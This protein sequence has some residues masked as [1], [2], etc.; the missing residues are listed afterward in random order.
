MR[1][2]TMEEGQQCFCRE[3]YFDLSGQIESST[4]KE[5]KGRRSFRGRGRRGKLLLYF[6]STVAQGQ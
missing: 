5:G 4:Q 3:M 1:Y 6:V 2:Y